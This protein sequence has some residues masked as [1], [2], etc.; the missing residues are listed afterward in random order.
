MIRKEAYRTSFMTPAFYIVAQR[1]RPSCGFSI[2]R[3]T[4]KVALPRCLD[5][6]RDAPMK[7]R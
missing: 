6:A 4:G 1:W 3:R 2:G 7:R 5:C